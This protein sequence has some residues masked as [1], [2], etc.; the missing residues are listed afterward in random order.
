MVSRLLAED[1]ATPVP[2]EVQTLAEQV[3]AALKSGD[4]TAL[5]TNWHSP[6]TLVKVK[7]IEE[8][9]EDGAPLSPEDSARE[10]ER[11]LKR[12]ARDNEVTVARAGQLRTLLQKHFG[13][14]NALTLQAV[15]I[16]E[17]ESLS[18]EL[19]G[20]DDVDLYL[21]GADG[22]RLRI[23]IDDALKV[24][25]VWKFKGRLE[26]QLTIELPDVD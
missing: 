14:L 8:A 19:M 10:S 12:R 1:E 22:T 18:P 11:E 4:D 25:G 26:D 20:Y 16:D 5:L 23:G 6:E 21:L 3:V 24:E 17:D 2:P 7:L 13:D 15:E 9:A